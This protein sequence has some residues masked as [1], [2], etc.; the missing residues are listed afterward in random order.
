MTTVIVKWEVL[1]SFK[2]ASSYR[3]IQKNHKQKNMSKGECFK[4]SCLDFRTT[5]NLEAFDT[6]PRGRLQRTQN[7]NPQCMLWAQQEM[8]HPGMC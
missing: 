4:K 5:G 2:K 6:R 1:K 7:S 3:Y 8:H